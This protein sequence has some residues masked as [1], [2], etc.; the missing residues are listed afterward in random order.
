MKKVL[1]I[2][3]V[4]L[5]LTASAWSAGWEAQKLLERVAYGYNE[6]R[7]FDVVR[8]AS[9]KLHLL[10]GGNGLYYT[11]FDG[12]SWSDVETVERQEGNIYGGFRCHALRMTLDGNGKIHIVSRR[13]NEVA[14]TTNA[15][16]TW[17]TVIVDEEVTGI[18]D[19]VVDASGFVHF[20]YPRGDGWWYVSD[21]GGTLEKKQVTEGM[22]V[23]GQRNFKV[24]IESGEAALYYCQDSLQRLG[25]SD[26][27]PDEWEIRTEVSESCDEFDLVEANGLRHLAMSDSEREPFYTYET[28]PDAWE[29]EDI[30]F[31]TDDE[32]AEDF[33]AE[34]SMVELVLDASGSPVISFVDTWREDNLSLLVR[35]ADELIP[36]DV[37]WN[38]TVLPFK[39]VKPRHRMI[40][41]ENGAEL[42]FTDTESD[43]RRYRPS[44]GSGSLIATQGE[45]V[46]AMRLRIDK[47]G[48]HH[49]VWVS[50]NRLYY[51][52]D[53]GGSWSQTDL[54]GSASYSDLDLEV[55]GNGTVFIVYRN[56]EYKRTLLRSTDT[57]WSVDTGFDSA[58]ENGLALERNSSGVVHTACAKDGT[59]LFGYF[60]ETTQEW[61]DP[62]ETVGVYDGTVSGLDL[63][64]YGNEPF[65]LLRIN[66]SGTDND[67]ALYLCRRHNGTWEGNT[68]FREFSGAGAGVVMAAG[69]TGLHLLY[70]IPAASFE[71][72]HSSGDFDDYGMIEYGFWDPNS[73]SITTEAFP[74]PDTP[75]NIGYLSADSEGRVFVTAGIASM[76]DGKFAN[77][78][79]SFLVRD[80]GRWSRQTQVESYSGGSNLEFYDGTL[81]R[82]AIGNYDKATTL[83]S[84]AADVA[85]LAEQDVVYG[86]AIKYGKQSN[87]LKAGFINTTGDTLTLGAAAISGSDAFRITS[88]G[89]AGTLGAGE[90]CEVGFVFAPSSGNYHSAALSVTPQ[91]SSA[92]GLRLYAH[93]VALADPAAAAAAGDDGGD[94]DGGCFIATAAYGTPMHADIDVLRHFRDRVLMTSGAG[95]WLVR[96]YYALSPA[97]A[98]WVRDASWRQAAVRGALK[99]FIWV[100][101]NPWAALTALLALI[102]GAWWLRRRVIG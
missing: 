86:Y 1:F 74:S 90:R 78:I 83:Y 16:G 26:S 84:H 79:S 81:Y 97:I 55:S 13:D 101:L 67:K 27:N 47:A 95:R 71:N 4:V 66:K 51:G 96:Q 18:S 91:G 24:R 48:G 36:T 50:D 34:D 59:V 75:A 28:N 19:I 43:L 35:Y 38:R 61:S 40:M 41:A 3:T 82:L 93:A 8:D 60:D 58:C 73:A 2:L 69:G 57:N 30:R 68:P 42:F 6:D 21:R 7:T 29:R 87:E 80:A 49:A 20:F 76:Q 44:D 72:Y 99:P 92:A 52:E 23:Y 46:G 17:Q 100:L 65:V 77:Y 89:C 98:D 54:G 94:D 102:G 62:G 33:G 45:W 70:G 22:S 39:S 5:G 32:G 9:G 63:A 88:D 37:T 53:T 10:F 64:F 25:H 11:V 85:L 14:Y 15:S 12:S 56:S 31:L